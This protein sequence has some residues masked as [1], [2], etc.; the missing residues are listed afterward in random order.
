MITFSIIPHAA[1]QGTKLVY[2]RH[3]YSFG[4]EPMPSG[5]KT[6]IVVNYVQ[7]HYGDERRVLCVDGYCSYRIWRP[8][9]LLPPTYFSAGLMVIT[10]TDFVTGAAFRLNELNSD[11]WPMYV[12]KKKCWICIGDPV[13]QGDQAIE[14]APNCVAVLK[15]NSLIALWLHP[16]CIK[17]R[18]GR[19]KVTIYDGKGKE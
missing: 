11:M 16:V 10:P 8:T 1:T 6:C 3:E 12:N 18:G 5:C 15:N 14:F 7:L 9:Q 2:R 13:N 4:T 17:G 19:N